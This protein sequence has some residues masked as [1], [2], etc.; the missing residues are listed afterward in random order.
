MKL[1]CLQEN[2]KKGLATVGRAVA[3]KSPL[4]VL[5]NVL[6]STEGDQ[7]KLAATDLEIGIRVLI[8]AR[9]EQEGSI[10]LPAK[11]FSD[12]VGNL[13]NDRVE[14]T[15][16]E[17]TQTVKLECGR[18]TNNIKGIESDDFP[19]I[20]TAE[21]E[22]LS[23]KLA[24]DI[25][26]QSVEQVAFA[27]S[28]DESRPVLTGVLLRLSTEDAAGATVTFA[29]ADGYRLAKRTVTIPEDVASGIS[30]FQDLII[31]ARA[32]S[33]LARAI[34]DIEHPVAVYITSTGGQVLFHTPTT[35]LVSRLIDGKFPDFERIIPSTFTTRTLVET[36]EL[37]KAV[38]LASFFASSNQNFIKLTID[39][40]E[41][42][43]PGKLTISANAAE[44]GDNTSV[45]D[46]TIGGEGGQIAMNFKFLNEALDAM[47]TPQVALETQTSQSPGVFRPIGD[48]TYVHIIMPMTLR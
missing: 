12:I 38:K 27:A 5:S 44:I 2:L 41:D 20:P 39:P 6:L 16:D 19:S 48:D 26:R 13:P 37:L 10:T 47:K 23:F 40:G 11:L 7:L 21:G 46:S 34:S 22:E 24:P 43:V 30:S 45:L 36:T 31:P 17:R 15:L 33:E 29:A 28:N 25:V 3:S 4:P 9:V 8:D 35:D 18:F 14:M 42:D 1:S 32:L